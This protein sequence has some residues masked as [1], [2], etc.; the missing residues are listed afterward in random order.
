MVKT[1]YRDFIE[2]SLLPSNLYECLMR[3]RVLLR[4]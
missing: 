3:L 4:L 2:F 1:Q